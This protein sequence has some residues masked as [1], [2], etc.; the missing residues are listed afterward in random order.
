MR[1]FII[2]TLLILVSKISIAQEDIYPVYKGCDSTNEITLESCFNQQLTKDVLANFRIPEK[3]N[4]DNYKG[5]INVVFL[6]NKE[7]DFEVLYVRS[8][9]QEH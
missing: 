1:N 6:V 5:I 9:Y 3:V 7:G 2:I 4:T 8:S